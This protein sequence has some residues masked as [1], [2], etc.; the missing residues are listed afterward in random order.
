MLTALLRSGKWFYDWRQ[1]ACEVDRNRHKQLQSGRAFPKRTK[2]TPVSPFLLETQGYL[3]LRGRD[4]FA[5]LP[6]AKIIVA[7]SF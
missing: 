3:Y 4:L 6:K 7:T 2:N 5:F 1:V